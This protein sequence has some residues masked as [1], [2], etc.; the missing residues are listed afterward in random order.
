MEERDKNEAANVIEALS[1]SLRDMVSSIERADEAAG[2]PCVFGTYAA[3]VLDD[4]AEALDDLRSNLAHKSKLLAMVLSESKTARALDAL[5]SG[6]ED[7]A[8]HECDYGDGCVP[9]SE[10][11]KRHYT[12]I[13]CKARQ[14]LDA[15]GLDPEPE[16]QP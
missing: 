7:I 14:A 4:A 11:M 13:P 2:R 1:E 16:E 10:P 12:C 6:L 8:E 3:A 9:F 15:A 5:R